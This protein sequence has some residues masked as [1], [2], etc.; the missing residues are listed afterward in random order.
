MVTFDAWLRDP[1]IS[2]KQSKEFKILKFYM[3]HLAL[4]PFQ[5]FVQRRTEAGEGRAAVAVDTEGAEAEEEV[6]RVRGRR[7]EDNAASPPPRPRRS[8]RRRFRLCFFLK[9]VFVF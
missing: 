1:L 3:T 8:S 6:R 9:T 4:D 7:A 5:G 2:P